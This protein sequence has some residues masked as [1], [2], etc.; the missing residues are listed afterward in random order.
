[1]ISVYVLSPQ[2]RTNLSSNQTVLVTV[3]ESERTDR[4]GMSAANTGA[5]AKVKVRFASI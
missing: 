2:F 4:S 1:M 5:V 3:E